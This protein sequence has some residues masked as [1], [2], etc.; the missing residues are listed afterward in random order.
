VRGREYLVQHRPFAGRENITSI[1][2]DA[3]EM[4]D[5]TRSEKHRVL[6]NHIMKS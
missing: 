3:A 6:M 1:F 2:D 5:R 4:P